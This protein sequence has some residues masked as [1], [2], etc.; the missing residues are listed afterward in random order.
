MSK[1]DALR[2]LGIDEDIYDSLLI[3]YK[4]LALDFIPKM[5]EAL[6]ARQFDQLGELAHTL[7]GAAGNL[8]IEDAHVLARTM[9]LNAKNDKQ[10][11]IIKTALDEYTQIIMSL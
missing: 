8:R 3:D 4:A 10:G 6:S 2:D 1:E 9:E 5:N 11:D 7:K